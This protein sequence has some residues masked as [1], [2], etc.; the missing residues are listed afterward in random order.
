MLK[1]ERKQGMSVAGNRDFKTAPESIVGLTRPQTAHPTDGDNRYITGQFSH[2][3]RTHT[4]A[5]Q[6]H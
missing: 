4:M 5:N 1:N 2:V 6:L 3:A